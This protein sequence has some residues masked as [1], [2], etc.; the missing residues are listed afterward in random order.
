MKPNKLLSLSIISSILVILYEFFQWKIIDILTEFLM[1]PILLLVFGFFI[2]ITVRA[3]VTLF[4]NKDWKP[5][6]IQLITI[7][8]LFFIPFNQIVL[9]INFKWNKSEREQV[10]KMV[11]NKTLKP[12]VSYNSSLIHLPKKYEHLSS[13]GGEIVVEKSGDSYQI[14]F[15]TY[16]GILDNFS[17]FVYTP[18]GQ[19]P[20]KKAFD[21]DMKEI[22]KMD[23]NWYFVSSS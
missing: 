8:L 23:K 22:D 12:N 15:F 17:G 7:I 6:L 18:N 19:K 20:S 16:R 5:I 4:K 10:A 2:Y 9:D 13:S 11:E 3:I 14:L 1:L 21:G